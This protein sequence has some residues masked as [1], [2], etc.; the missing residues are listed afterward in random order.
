MEKTSCSD[1]AAFPELFNDIDQFID[2]CAQGIKRLGFRLV[3]LAISAAPL[4][5]LLLDR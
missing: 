3:M 5:T 4:A 2:E 1:I